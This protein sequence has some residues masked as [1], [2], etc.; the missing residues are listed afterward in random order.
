MRGTKIRIMGVGGA[1][2]RILDRLNE[3]IYDASSL[4]AVNTDA[5]AL[6]AARAAV[7]LQIGEALTN[8]LGAGGDTSVGRQAARDGES[9]IRS[10]LAGTDML[11][12]LAGL[13]GGTGTGAV[14]VIMDQAHEEGVLV[15]C[16]V[17]MPFAFE[18]QNRMK[19]A[20][21]SLEILRESADALLVVPN[22]R[23]SE[24]AGAE[25]LA[26][27]FDLVDD[28]LAKGVSGIEKLLT[29]PG[30]IR[31]DFAD[32]KNMVKSGGG[33]CTFGF[34]EGCGKG[35]ARQAA[36]SLLGNPLLENGKVVESAAAVLLSMVGGPD[37]TLKDVGEITD[38]LSA[39][40]PK[41]CRLFIGT[42][43][44]ENWEGRV[45]LTALVSDE[46]RPDRTGDS[47]EDTWAA[48]AR[49]GKQMQTKLRLESYGK[50]RFKDVEPTV[51]DGEDLDIPT[52]VRRGI[53]IGK[54]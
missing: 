12:L 34:G 35:K 42:V 51:M 49:K 19:T 52:F 48:L 20:E 13:G 44:D 10:L 46:W 31:L 3:H 41:G 22:Q 5:Q 21:E 14:P 15:L 54:Q 16:F 32:L 26:A 37:L 40:A 23:L 33:L 30:L 9:M 36:E 2:C 18:G 24:Y 50:G 11:L 7:K 47:D 25:T 53:L 43:V 4:V 28:V 38:A 6:N 1:G 8:G 17:S 39:R 27:T 45:M 29:Q